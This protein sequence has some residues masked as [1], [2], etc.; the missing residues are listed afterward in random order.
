MEITIKEIADDAQVSISTVSRVLNGS[1]AVS[2]ELRTRVLQS[3]EKY[4]Y[5]P[6]AAARSLVT[7]STDLVAVMVA[8]LSNPTMT[9]QLKQINDACMQH[10]KVMLVC[11]Y[12]FDNEK[13]ILLLDKMLEHN[14]DGLIFQGV[15]LTDPI[16]EKL[17][18]F[19]CPVV[20]GAQG[21]PTET[22]E[23]TTVTVDSYQ[24]ARDVANFLISEGHRRIAYIGGNS[25]DYTNGYLRLK[26]IRDALESAGLE[27]PESY[28]YQESFTTDAGIRGMKQIYE[29]N[30]KLPTAVI[31]G[32]DIVGIG[33][34]R[35]LKS[36][37][38]R[39][40]DDMSVFGFDDSVS[41]FF[42]PS[43]STVR[44]AKQGEIFYDALFG[45]QSMKKEKEWIYIPHQ[46]VR[47]SSTRKI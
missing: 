9:E 14:I 35:Y 6:N 20:L 17:R 34:I 32:S 43:L 16:L 39:V 4:H 28:V 25:D 15:W 27:L 22:C 47:R 38:M 41:E 44:S 13:A 40:P 33:V 2:E 10:G 45:E 3:V 30:L 29:N 37:G 24:A 7:R 12:S 46:L 1:K 19:Q 8:D 42:D 18:E 36:Q 21:T 23:F 26:G 31:A 5:R 11:D